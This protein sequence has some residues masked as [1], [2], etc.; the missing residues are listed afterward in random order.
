[1]EFSRQ[2]TNAQLT[3]ESGVTFGPPCT[4]LLAGGFYVATF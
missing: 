3:A 4:F 1:M 2:T